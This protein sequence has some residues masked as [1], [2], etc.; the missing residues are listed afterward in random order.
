[1]HDF[2]YEAPTSLAEAVGLLGSRNGSARP[3]A[4]GTDLIDQ[5]RLKR[6]EPSVVVDI[7]RIPELNVLQIGADGLRLGSAVPCHR[8]YEESAI[9]DQYSALSDS[10][11]IIGGV[12]IQSRA[13]LGGNLCNSG[14]AADSTPS[15]IALGGVCVIAGP[16]GT[17][18]LPVE[19]FCT[20]PGQNALQPGE[21]LVEIR[22]GTRPANSGS[23]YRRFIPRNEMDIAVVGV[24]ASVELDESRQNFVAARIALGAVAPTPLFVEAAGQAL[25]GQP[26]DD[27]SIA[28]AAEA[29][30]QAATPITDMRGTKEYRIH[31]TGVLTERVV[32]TAVARARGEDVTY[33]PGH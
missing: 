23:H 28:K 12:Q 8:V 31:I 5:M 30:R 10:A 13:S 17:R 29:A 2:E 19:S 14:P 18:E 15:M 16:D 25:A 24:G 1:M 3:L 4:G 27:N 26:V 9:V 6:F 21:L 33:R 22:F 7:K 20:G 11:A 32:K